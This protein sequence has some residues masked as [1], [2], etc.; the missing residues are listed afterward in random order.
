MNFSAKVYQ[1]CKKIPLG[2][3]TTYKEMAKMMETKAYRAVGQVL[4]N[5]PFAPKVPCHRVVKSDGYIGGFKGKKE[6]KEIKQKIKLLK[7]EGIVIKNKKINLEKYL[8]CFK[9]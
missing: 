9:D 7:R 4:K 6:G 8:F 2:K 1:L 3:V 5:N